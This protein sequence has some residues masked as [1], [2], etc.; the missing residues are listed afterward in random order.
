MK[1]NDL[2]DKLGIVVKDANLLLRVQDDI[3][4][5]EGEFFS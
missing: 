4:Y 3:L 5:I 2:I 1:Y